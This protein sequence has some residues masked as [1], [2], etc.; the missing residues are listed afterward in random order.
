MTPEEFCKARKRLGLTAARLAERLGYH[1]RSIYA[2]ELGEVAVPRTVALALS[3]LAFGL[4][5]APFK[6]G[7]ELLAAR[8]RL[9]VSQT[10]MAKRLGY[11]PKHIGRM[12]RD[13]V[14]MLSG[15]RLA[16]ACAFLLAGRKENPAT[17]VDGLSGRGAEGGAVRNVSR[18]PGHGRIEPDSRNRSEVLKG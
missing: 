2:F 11:T 12:E 7:A 6:S 16:L 17:L 13:D 4:D 14:P 10:I 15:A 3:A 5:P 18:H 9:G 1:E 8:R